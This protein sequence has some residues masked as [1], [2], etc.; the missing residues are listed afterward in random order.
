MVELKKYYDEKELI[1]LTQDWSEYLAT[2]MCLEG[3]R[4][5]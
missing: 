5:L 4:Q 3:K 1:N 2:R